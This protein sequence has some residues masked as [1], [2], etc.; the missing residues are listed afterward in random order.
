MRRRAQTDSGISRRWPARK[1][2]IRQYDHEVQEEAS[3]SRWSARRTTGPTIAAVLRPVLSSRA[4]T[5]HRMRD[6]PV[7]RRLRPGRNG[8]C[9]RS[10]KRSATA[11][12][13]EPIQAAWP[14]SITS[15]GAIPIDRRR[16]ARWSGRPS[17]ATTLLLLMR[18]ALHQRQGQPQQRVQLRRQ[19]NVEKRLPFPARC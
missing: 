13:W 5:R 1:W 19:W 10:T 18:R 8:G 12:P 7:V 2:I 15:A 14:F 17:P 11:W 6:E 16:W 9:V 4:R 3:S